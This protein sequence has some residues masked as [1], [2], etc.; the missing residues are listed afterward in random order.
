MKLRNALYCSEP[1]FFTEE[2][3][4]DSAS[5]NVNRTTETSS[6]TGFILKEVET[7][8][9]EIRS[10]LDIVPSEG[11]YDDVPLML[12]LRSHTDEI[13][14]MLTGGTLQHPA[15]GLTTISQLIKDINRL[16]MSVENV[17]SSS[18]NIL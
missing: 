13:G 12:R 4:I 1:G 3:V 7:V 5:V 9:L 11:E 16:R 18:C 2:I 6:R 8:M 10:D 15:D 14:K 17:T